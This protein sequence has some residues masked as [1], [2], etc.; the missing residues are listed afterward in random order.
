MSN[1]MSYIINKLHKGEFKKIFFLNKKSI[2]QL[3]FKKP[4]NIACQYSGCAPS[5]DE[6]S[7]ISLF[8]HQVH[9]RRRAAPIGQSSGCGRGKETRRRGSPHY[10]QSLL[11]QLSMGGAEEGNQA[12]H[13]TGRP[14]ER[15]REVYMKKK[16]NNNRLLYHYWNMSISISYVPSFPPTI[17]QERLN[18]PFIHLYLYA[19]SYPVL[20]LSGAQHSSHMQMFHLQTVNLI[21]HYH[22]SLMGGRTMGEMWGDRWRQEGQR[23]LLLLIAVCKLSTWTKI[24]REYI[25]IPLFDPVKELCNLFDVEI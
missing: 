9:R 2:S 1:I 25:R 22:C 3:A 12:V 4:H 8:T 16:N 5:I 15:D 19:S 23:L 11:W 17:C 14:V 7:T 20:N 13:P 21:S 18:I 24:H 10:S 6:L